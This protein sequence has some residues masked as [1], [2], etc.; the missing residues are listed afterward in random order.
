MDLNF[1]FFLLI[2]RSQSC[3]VVE[4][5]ICSALTLLMCSDVPMGGVGYC[6]PNV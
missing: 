2:Q 4:V 5:F 1:R 6:T 3:V